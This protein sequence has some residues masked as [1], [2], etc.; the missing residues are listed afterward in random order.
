RCCLYAR[1][2]TPA[3]LC[4]V[5]GEC[6]CSVGV[7]GGEEVRT[8]GRRWEAEE[9]WRGVLQAA[10]EL[11]SQAE[12][13]DSLSRELQQLS[14]QQ[15]STLAWVRELQQGLDA[16]EEHA[17]TQ[18]KLNR[19]QSVLSLRSEG[20]SRLSSLRARVESV[21]AREGVEEERRC[22][23]RET[24][25]GAEEQWRGVLQ[26]AQELR[27]QAELQDSLSRELQQLST[28]QE[29]TLAWVRELQQGLDAL[30]RG[31]HGS[32]EHLE[33]RL[34]R[35]QA[36][37]NVKSEGNGKLASLKK[38][39]ESLC[40]RE[41]LDESRRRGFL[42]SLRDTDIEWRGVLQAAQEQHSVLK[43]VMERV[44][45]CQYQKQQTQDR[46]GQLRKQTNELPHRFPWPGLGDRRQAVDQ[47][48]VLLE[49]TRTLAPSL[50]GLRAMGRELYQITHDSS[51]TDHTWTAME[52]SVPGLLLELTELVKT[53]EEGIMAE[54]RC[55]QLVEQHNAAQD[56]LRE[57]VKGLPAPPTDRQDLQAT[58]NTLKA[59]LQTVDREQR[60]MKE[61]DT[62]RDALIHLCTPGG[63]DSL[64]L[65]II[66]LH[67]LCDSSEQEVRE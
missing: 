49:K 20:D 32:P 37:L 12:L 34:N 1:R 23:L 33:E 3:C 21:C 41:D 42:Q 2:V 15:E 64:S 47:A 8:A 29:S 13:Q 5:C 7:E 10:Q 56:W 55:V 43:R 6:V 58:I 35:A 65:E 48:R 62:T 17:S 39:V 25:G 16:L 19:A 14:T 54:R 38:K 46:L 59:L 67:E 18:D 30:A 27:S 26:A 57:Q 24:L 11:R 28:Q 53:L 9:Q 60:E 50:A 4:G 44:V 63:Q 40:A 52:E 45:S 61:C 51:W 22:A 31:T 36:I 66:H